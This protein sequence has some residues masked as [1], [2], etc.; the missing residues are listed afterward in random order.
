[1][2]N[3]FN[4]GDILYYIGRLHEKYYGQECTVIYKR[5][6]HEKYMYKIQFKDDYILEVGEMSIN[7]EI[8]EQEKEKFESPIISKNDLKPLECFNTPHTCHNPIKFYERSCDICKKEKQ[9]DYEKKY[10]YKELK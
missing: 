1:M 7:L 8:Q 10:K 2:K 4:V 6:S 3:K 5:K 9:C